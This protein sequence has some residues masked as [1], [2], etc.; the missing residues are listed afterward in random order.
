M[1]I[2]DIAAEKIKEILKAEGKESWGIRL[3]MEQGGGCCSSYGLDLDEKPSENDDVF[4]N[5]GAKVFIDKDL[6]PSVSGLTIDFVKQG[7]QEGF[8]LSGGPSACGGGCGPDSG[9]SSCGPD[10][11]PSS[12]GCSSC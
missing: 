7:M 12:C 6:S 5:A 2:T 9:P 4:E 10:S 11:G 8:V 3:Y 1:T